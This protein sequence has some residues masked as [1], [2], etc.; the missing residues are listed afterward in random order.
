MEVE[1]VRGGGQR[2]R[3][4][5]EGIREGKRRAK[6]DGRGERK[7]RRAGEGK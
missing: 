2:R 7:R 1:H 3:A 5:E 6:E 4:E